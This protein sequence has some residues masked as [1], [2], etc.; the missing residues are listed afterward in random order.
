MDFVQDLRTAFMGRFGE[1]VRIEAVDFSKRGCHLD[2]T[3][4]GTDI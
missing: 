2:I 4:S 1:K 3:V